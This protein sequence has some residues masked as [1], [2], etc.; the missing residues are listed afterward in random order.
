MKDRTTSGWSRCRLKI[1]LILQR[2]FRS[3]HAARTY[4]RAGLVEFDRK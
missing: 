2:L 4:Q 3:Q 1:R